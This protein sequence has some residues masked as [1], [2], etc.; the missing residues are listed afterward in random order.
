MSISF[1]SVAAATDEENIN[2]ITLPASVDEVFFE[3]IGYLNSLKKLKI[4]STRTEGV[5][6]HISNSITELDVTE[7]A[8]DTSFYKNEVVVVERDSKLGLNKN[9]LLV[10]GVDRL[11]LFSGSGATDALISNVADTSTL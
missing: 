8:A 5:I 6:I 7:L 1:G 2:T 9:K 3:E 4:I 10:K 11:N